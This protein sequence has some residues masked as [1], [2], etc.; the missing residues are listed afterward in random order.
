MGLS[1]HSADSI[2]SGGRAGC[3]PQL[4]DGMAQAE[5]ARLRWA[6]PK[7]HE[8]HKDQL[9]CCYVNVNHGVLSNAFTFSLGALAPRKLL[10]KFISQIPDNNTQV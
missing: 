1:I 3:K 7:Q 2:L 10:M 5:K 6:G 9:G 4:K 8:N